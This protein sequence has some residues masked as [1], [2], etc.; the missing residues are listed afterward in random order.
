ME[1]ESMIPVF[2][3]EKTVHA[4]DRVTTV[5]DVERNRAL[6]NNEPKA[7]GQILNK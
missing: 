6:E 1:F 2:K 5:V 3:Q 4:L 7:A